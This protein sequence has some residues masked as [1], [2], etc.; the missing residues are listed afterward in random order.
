[1]PYQPIIPIWGGLN[2]ANSASATGLLDPV[3]GQQYN[4]GGL[5]RGDYFD[6]TEAEANRLSVTST[7]LCHAGRYRYVLVD[8][9]ATAANVKTGTVGYLRSGSFV[10][11][12]Q[13][14]TVGSGQTAG[15]YTVNAT[16]GSG[17]G[18]GA[19]IQV[20][21]SSAGTIS[22]NPTVLNGGAGYVSPPTFSLAALGGSA[23]T[24]SVQLNSTPNVVTSTDQIGVAIPTA[25][26]VRP[27]VFLNS[28]TPGNYGFIQELGLA[29]VLANATVGTAAIGAFVNAVTTNSGTVTTTAQSGSPIGSTIGVA[30]DTPQNSILFKAQLG[31]ACMTV[32]D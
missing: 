2:N 13:T 3:T 11:A 6:L 23:G 30:I 1:M 26:P 32:Q 24:L 10:Q 4:T 28:I 14:I 31:Y 19:S 8:S 27:V 29:T 9:G 12:V 17:G 7:G 21:V 22:G 25:I 18:S 5:D 16:V 20:V 15:T